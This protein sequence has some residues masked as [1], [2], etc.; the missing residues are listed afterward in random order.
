MQFR[1][2]SSDTARD[3]LVSSTCFI[4]LLAPP[5]AGA[6]SGARKRAI[7]PLEAVSPLGEEDGFQRRD[8]GRIAFQGRQP[9]SPACCLIL[10]Q[11]TSTF[12]AFALVL[13]GILEPCIG[14]QSLRFRG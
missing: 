6:G 10:S 8:R 4:E 13:S 2:N 3:D 9:N 1:C 5:T 12:S 11:K 14:R 7:P